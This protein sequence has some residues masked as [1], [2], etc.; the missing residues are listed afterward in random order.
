MVHIIFW[1]LWCQKF[2]YEENSYKNVDLA[3]PQYR[4]QATIIAFAAM[5]ENV[6]Q[7]V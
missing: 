1:T 3:S 6:P 7:T 4:C 5:I 2:V